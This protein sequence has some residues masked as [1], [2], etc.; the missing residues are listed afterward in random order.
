MK[1]LLTI[2]CLFLSLGSMAQCPL[3]IVKYNAG[4]NRIHISESDLDAV[5]QFTWG[6]GVTGYTITSRIG[7]FGGGMMGATLGTSEN[8]N[9]PSLYLFGGIQDGWVITVSKVCDGTT[10]LLKTIRDNNY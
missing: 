5:Y 10:Y 1:N 2:L 6:N 3:P 8:T 7:Q 4:Q 9:D